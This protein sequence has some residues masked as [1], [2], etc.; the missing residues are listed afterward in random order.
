MQEISDAIS[1]IAIGVRKA[2]DPY[3]KFDVNMNDYLI[4]SIQKIGEE[5]EVALAILEVPKCI[6][7]ELNACKDAKT[8][9]SML[10][11]FICRY[12]PG[13]GDGDGT[14]GSDDYADDI[15]GEE[16]LPDTDYIRIGE[17][18]W[19][20]RLKCDMA[21]VLR[22]VIISSKTVG[23]DKYIEKLVSMSKR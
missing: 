2:S 16:A 18:G 21:R 9:K 6:D 20:D 17:D 13:Y 8:G 4:D 15:A 14:W 19:E 7:I 23:L 12:D 5:P 11:Y 10:A 3:I 1:Y 22:L